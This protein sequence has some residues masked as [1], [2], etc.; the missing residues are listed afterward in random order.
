MYLLC[1]I[2]RI[3][4]PIQ[5]MVYFLAYSTLRNGVFYSLAYV[6]GYK[7]A[8]GAVTTFL[9]TKQ[10]STVAFKQSNHMVSTP[11]HTQTQGVEST[12]QLEEAKKAVERFS[13]HPQIILCSHKIS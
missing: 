4:I 11:P 6:T 2:D 8:P 3:S 12:C 1:K 10:L 13:G 5:A 9:K 7:S